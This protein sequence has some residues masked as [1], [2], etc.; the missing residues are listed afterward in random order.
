MPKNLEKRLRELEIEKEWR[1][2]RP[3]HCWEQLKYSEESK[4]IEETYCHS[5]SSKNKLKN[6]RG[7]R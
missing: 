6:L 2:S 1:L 4:K 5:D 7:I 3:Q